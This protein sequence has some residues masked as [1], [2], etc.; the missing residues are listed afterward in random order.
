MKNKIPYYAV[1][2]TSTQTDDIEGYSEMA[3]KMETLARQQEGF[4][5][6]ESARNTVGITVSYWKSL[7]AI[8]NWKANTEHL[9]AQQ[10]GREQWYNWYNVKICKVEREYEY[11]KNI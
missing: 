6:I 2:F 5:G 4:I 10:K 1:I 9:L 8:K 11:E 7:E 3:E